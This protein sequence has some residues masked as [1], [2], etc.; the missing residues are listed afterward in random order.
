MRVEKN[1]PIHCSPSGSQSHVD[2]HPRK[3][4]QI[5]WQHRQTAFY[6]DNSI[7]AVAVRRS[8]CRQVLPSSREA[9][10]VSSSSPV[11]N[12]PQSL[13]A[14]YPHSFDCGDGCL[15]GRTML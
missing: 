11:P 10:R 7:V 14:S 9:W 1:R 4:E 2:G 6:C 3:T 5:D 13:F 12:R 8:R 15:G